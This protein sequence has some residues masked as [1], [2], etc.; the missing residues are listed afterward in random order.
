MT[1]KQLL[2]RYLKE[3]GEYGA[4]SK[5]TPKLI[6]RE[7]N[8]EL[9]WCASSNCWR[10]GCL[11]KNIHEFISAV[12]VNIITIKKGDIVVAKTQDGKY[13]FS[14]IVRDVWYSTFSVITESGGI[15][16][17]KRIIYVNSRPYDFNNGWEF[18]NKKA[19]IG[20][21]GK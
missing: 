17:L 21:N 12:A 11:Y 19:F 1:F 10:F 18:K 8:F 15:I 9:F 14:Y 20:I 2:I 3:H 4:F 7:D 6:N 5:R 13:S 16:S